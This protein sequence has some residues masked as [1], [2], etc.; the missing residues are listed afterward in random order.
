MSDNPAD[1]HLQTQIF[2]KLTALE[3]LL[4]N[5]WASAIANGP[6]PV[7]SAERFVE[8]LKDKAEA[9]YGDP[10][11]DSDMAYSIALFS[12]EY[13]ARFGEKV[14]HRRPVKIV[15]RH[16]ATRHFKDL[17]HDVTPRDAFTTHPFTH[18]KTGSPD[19]RR[20]LLG[21]HIAL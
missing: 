5:L 13:L 17:G 21:G 7:Q 14:L 4:E 1:R 19:P 6:H 2:G 20:E 9:I 16:L 18:R 11:S 10:G 12:A 15:C 8:D 3:F